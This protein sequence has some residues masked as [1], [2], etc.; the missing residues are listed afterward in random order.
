MGRISGAGF[1]LHLEGAVILAVAVALYGRVGAGWGLFAALILA[2]DLFMLGY[3]FGPRAGA[4][5]Y[6]AAHIYAVPLAV[7]AL[8]VL[9]GLQTATAVGLVWLAHIGMDRSVGFGLKYASGFSDTH[10]SRL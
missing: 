2:P 4:Y 3:L 10:F 5:V 7:V 1:L 9:L 6:N 8:G